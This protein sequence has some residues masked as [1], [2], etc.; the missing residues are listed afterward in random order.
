MI[1]HPPTS[2]LTGILFPYTTL[3]RS[4]DHRIA[5]GTVRERRG[6]AGFGRQPLRRLAGAGVGEGNT[7]TL[8]TEAP[9]DG[10]PDAAAAAEH[11][12][13]LALKRGHRALL[14]I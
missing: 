10:G 8:P 3:A 7:R 4:R 13:G 12:N 5:I 6:A 9:H 1:R 11:Q 2:T 14:E